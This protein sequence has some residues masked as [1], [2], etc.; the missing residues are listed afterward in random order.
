MSFEVAVHLGAH[1]TASTHL[2]NFIHENLG[3]F[4]RAG[5][6]FYKPTQMR[7]AITPAVLRQARNSDERNPSEVAAMVST[8]AEAANASKLILAD[9]NL[10]GSVEQIRKRGRLYPDAAKI[11]NYLAECLGRF[12]VS[13]VYLSIRSYGDYLCSAYWEAIRHQPFV[14]FREFT[15]PFDPHPDYWVDLAAAIHAAFPGATLFV[16]RYEDYAEAEATVVN[17]MAGADVHADFEP[18]A[19]ARSYPSPSY[20]AIA[21]LEALHPTLSREDIGKV[22]R[23]FELALR[24][25]SGNADHDPLTPMERAFLA[26]K[27]ERE[28]PQVRR[29]PGVRF[30][31]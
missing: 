10:I 11:L 13:E 3:V 16:W 26:S 9:E 8:V 1:K 15:A 20:A 30:I 24:D 23:Q 21:A 6:H 27:Y 25:K 14:T 28:V 5:A 29:A 19:V 7:E 31:G 4:G 12:T 18:R 17:L 2:Q 22:R